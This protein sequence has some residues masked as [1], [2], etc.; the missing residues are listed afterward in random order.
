[1]LKEIAMKTT[2]EE[3]NEIFNVAFNARKGSKTV[4]IR[5]DLLQNLLYDH[6]RLQSE[7]L[8]RP[9]GRGIPRT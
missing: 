1:M 2:N 6:Q 7:H 3:Y 4:R 8:K 5:I 9:Q